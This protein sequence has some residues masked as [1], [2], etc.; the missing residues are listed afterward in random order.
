MMGSTHLLMAVFSFWWQE[1]TPF[2]GTPYQ[3]GGGT[4]SFIWM[5]IQTMLALALVCG[6]A[7][8]IFRWVLPRLQLT[9][10]GANSM[11]RVV[12]RVML[13]ARRSLLVIEVAGRWLL[14]SSSETGVQLISELDAA[15]AESAAEAVARLRPNLRDSTASTRDALAERFSRLL[16]KR[17]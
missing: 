9:P 5:L 2:D 16:N 7:L 10:A 4:A 13:D 14:V 8:L 11:V 17:K 15:E 12:D 3:G 1:P 6:L